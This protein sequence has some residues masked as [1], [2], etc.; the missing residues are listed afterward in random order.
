MNFGRKMKAGVAALAAIATLGAGG[1]VASTAFAGGGGGNQPGEGGDLVA[2]QFW[3]YKDDASG[4]WGPA[5]SLD[6]VRAAMNNANVTLKGD[7]VTKAQAA[8]DQARTE[9]ETGFRRRHPGE[10]DGD[11]RVVAV[12]AV[13]AVSGGNYI[14]NGSGWYS[15]TGTGGWY[16]NWNQ[17][18]APY[19]YYYAGT[20]EYG[21]ATPFSD[22]P[23]NSVDAIMRR[24]V[25]AS[26]KP[27]IVVIVLDKYQPAPPSYHLS[28]STQAAE[29]SG[30]S[31]DAAD[32]SDVI[33]LSTD[34]SKTE[35]V[36]GTAT[37]HWRGIDG[38]EKTVAKQF[39]SSNKGNATVSA[40][41]TDMDASWESWPAGKRWW[42]VDIARQGGMAEAVSHKGESDAKESGEKTPTPPSKWLTNE[43]GDTVTDGNDSIAS[44]SLYTAHIKAH[45]NASSRFW[46]YD[47]IDTKDVV[48]GGTEKDGV[49]KVTVTDAHGNIVKADISIDDSIDGKRVVKAHAAAPHSGE[50]TLNVPQSA[51]PTGSD[52]TIEDGSVACW[53]G[54]NGTGSLAD[55]QT[56]DSDSVGKVTP[57]PD[58]VWVLDESGAL[59]AED[60]D[61][62]NQQ[63]V[64]QKTFL[65]GDQVGVVVNGSV[66]AH[67]LNPLASYS[68]TDDLTG[69]VQWIDWK[70][71]K[72]KVFVDGGDVT[73]QFDIVIDQNA[74]T[75]TA[76]AKSSYIAKTMFKNNASKVKFYL[77]GTIKQGATKGKKIQLTNKAYE[78]WNNETRPTNEPPVFVWTPNPNKAWAMKADGKWQLTVDPAKSD[79]VGG[80]DKYY[81][82]GDEVADWAACPRS[83]GPTTSP[84]SMASST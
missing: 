36:S 2:V 33:S 37:L 3:Q 58:K 4:A 44:G 22:D 6:S 73:D 65:V 84:T 40:S 27:S 75:A 81:R 82:L 48:I 47:T 32:A 13:P 63:G 5:T 26:S 64:D 74:K 78:K 70:S 79:K 50:Y 68:I 14:Y 57:T 76:T 8:L 67:L 60:K 55:C 10:G 83:R 23:S 35:N 19:K 43:A 21:T 80:D 45:S 38:T 53:N 66:P 59:V 1:V 42:D 15:P 62:T 69:S 30:Q 46:I 18:V 52:Y 71:G 77:T 72:G 25:G 20:Q 12:G 61:W 11:C 31:G 9:C 29:M 41:Y 49:S 7:G 39:T 54:D 24:N 51:K 16:D 56:G 17:Y 34:G 28:V